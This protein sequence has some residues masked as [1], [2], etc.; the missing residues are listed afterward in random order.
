MNASGAVPKSKPLW[1]NPLALVLISAAITG[2]YKTMD[3]YAS[4]NIFTTLD[5]N[6]TA[7][8]AYLVVGAWVGLLLCFFVFAP[9]LGKFIDPM[10]TGLVLKGFPFHKYAAITGVT[11][12]GSTFFFLWGNHYADPSVVVALANL[13]ILYTA[14]FEYFRRKGKN[15][16]GMLRW[17]LLVTLGGLAVAYQGEGGAVKDWWYGL[18][19]V[20]FASSLLDGINQ[21][22]E[23]YN[24]DSG[25]PEDTNNRIDVVTFFFWRFFYLTLT[26]TIVTFLYLVKTQDYVGFISS[27]ES[28][29]PMIVFVVVTMVLVFVAI[30]FRIKAKQDMSPTVVVA[31]LTVQVVIASILTLVV[32]SISPGLLGEVVFDPWVWATR[33]VGVLCI[34]IGAYVLQRRYLNN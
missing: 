11:S 30:S 28:A 32:N 10:Y 33:V 18:L 17:V 34:A 20:G 19:L 29:T 15:K 3:N 21:V 8:F 6:V 23:K 22:Y 26:S 24:A 4:R 2:L 27:V 16:N 1:R 14:M 7:T 12:A 31:V 9:F 25:S 13:T 5:S